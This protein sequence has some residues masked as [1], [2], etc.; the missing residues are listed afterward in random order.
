[1]FRSQYIST[2]TSLKSAEQF[3]VKSRNWPKVVV[4]INVAQLQTYNVEIIDLTNERVLHKHVSAFRKTAIALARKNKE[5]LIRNFVPPSCVKF[6]RLLKYPKPNF[7]YESDKIFLCRSRFGKLYKY[8]HRL[9]QNPGSKT[10]WKRRKYHYN[11]LNV[12]TEDSHRHLRFS[13]MSVQ[14]EPSDYVMSNGTR[15]DR[16]SERQTR[17]TFNEP[18]LYHHNKTHRQNR[19][20][21]PYVH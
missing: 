8:S 5:V 10:E 3:A 12:R 6:E 11:N 20:W 14:A 18:R 4:R 19:C 15:H 21:Y 13:R 1:M 9:D 7:I 2:T 17:S 16:I